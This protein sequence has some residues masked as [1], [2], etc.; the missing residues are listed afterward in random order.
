M[1]HISNSMIKG[2][3]SIENSA[4]DATEPGVIDNKNLLFYMDEGNFVANQRMLAMRDPNFYHI[5]RSDFASPS[6]YNMYLIKN[7]KRN[8]CK[9]FLPSESKCPENEI[10]RF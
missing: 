5:Q 4:L 1:T 2:Q 10:N 6:V 9:A 8:K 7:T 3:A